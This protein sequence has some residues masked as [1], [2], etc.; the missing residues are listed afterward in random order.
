MAEQTVPQAGV[1]PGTAVTATGARAPAS[2][3]GSFGFGEVGERF[4]DS[5]KRG[6]L[7][8]AIGLVLIMVVLIDLP[9]LKWSYLKYDFDQEDRT[10]GKE[11]AHGR[12]NCC[13]A[14]AG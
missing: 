13:E 6:D 2:A 12:R 11:E 1:A 8:F 3:G 7:G 9:P 5:L 14:A 4:V 10:N